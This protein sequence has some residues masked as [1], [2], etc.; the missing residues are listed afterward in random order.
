MT[1]RPVRPT[2]RVIAMAAGRHHGTITVMAGTAPG[3]IPGISA[4]TIPGI[5]LGTTPGMALGTM[6]A[7]AIMAT[8]VGHPPGAMAGTDLYIIMVVA[9]VPLPLTIASMPIVM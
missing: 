1:T 9:Y 4:G 5:V 2:G 6:A 3:T 7:M 8:M